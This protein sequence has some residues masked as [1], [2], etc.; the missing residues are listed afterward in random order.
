MKLTSSHAYDARND[1]ARQSL[2]VSTTRLAFMMLLPANPITKQH[3]HIVYPLSKIK[4]QGTRKIPSTHLLL[5]FTQNTKV[6]NPTTLLATSSSGLFGGVVTRVFWP[7]TTSRHDLR[8][9]FPTYKRVDCTEIPSR[10][11]P[12]NRHVPL[13]SRYTDGR[14][15]PFW[16]RYP[17]HHHHKWWPLPV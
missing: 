14:S 3:V 5:C 15:V 1:I 17:R 16:G 7:A 11:R 2:T 10:Q 13:A 12:T 6:G 9:F 4:H 8:R